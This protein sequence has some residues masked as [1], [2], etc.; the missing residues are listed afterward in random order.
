MTRLSAVVAVCVLAIL[1]GA[2]AAGG[3]TIEEII[4]RNLDAKGGAE[5]LRRIQ[6]AKQ[7]STITVQGLEG[8]MV[9]YAKRPNLTRQEM[10]L[11][12]QTV[13]QAFDGM[14][15]WTQNPLAGVLEPTAILGPEAELIRAQAAFDG[16]FVDYQLRGY[17]MELLGD[18]SLNGAAVHHVKMTDSQGRVQHAY[19]DITSGL[20]VRIVTENGSLTLEQDLSDYREVGGIKKP[21]FVRLSANGEAIGQITV[22]RV[23]L[24]V[25]LDDALFKIEKKQ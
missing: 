22:Q 17:T 4:A 14:T 9:I 21:F 19:L 6:S 11:A 13:I 1:I 2:P 3:Q 20:E 23:E 24:D 10:T 18:E 15:A 25:R 8:T 16:P 12:G 5:Q 7:T